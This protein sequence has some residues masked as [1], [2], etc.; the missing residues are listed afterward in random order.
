M[1]TFNLKSYLAYKAKSVFIFFI[2]F[3]LTTNTAFGKNLLRAVAENDL[4]QVV[5]LLEDGANPNIVFGQN[6]NMHSINR[7]EREETWNHP[8]AMHGATPLH[9]VIHD[10]GQNG[11]KEGSVPLEILDILLNKGANPHHFPMPYIKNWDSPLRMAIDL[12]RLE[13]T[14]ALLRAGALPHHLLRA[15]QISSLEIVKILLEAGANPDN[16]HLSAAIQRNHLG[17]VKVLLKAKAPPNSSNLSEAVQ[18]NSFGI[19]KALL[20]AGVD[21]NFSPEP[22]LILAIQHRN[23]RMVKTLLDAE[24]DVYQKDEQGRTALRTINESKLNSY[25]HG[26]HNMYYRNDLSR[27]KAIVE[28]AEDKACAQSLLITHLTQPL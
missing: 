10:S 28:E 25:S 12:K 26:F 16:S 4:N 18:N 8:V 23:L 9:I 20:D 21:P 5:E 19:V 11:Q 22:L 1:D 24:I 14:K 2:L 17:I 6:G 13:A 7:S 3:L 27:I 15:I